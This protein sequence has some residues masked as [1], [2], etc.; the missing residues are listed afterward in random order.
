MRTQ[1]S[2]VAQIGFF[3]EFFSLY[4]EEGNKAEPEDDKVSMNDDDAIQGLIRAFSETTV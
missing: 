3:P 4:L 2:N 1:F